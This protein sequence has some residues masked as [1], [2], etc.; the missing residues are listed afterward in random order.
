MSRVPL[1]SV[2]MGVHDGAAHLRPAIA[3]IL[4]QSLDDLELVVVDDASSDATPELLAGFDDPRLVVLRND[5]NIGLTRSLNR[6]LAVARGG[7]VA[8]QDADDRSLPNRLERQVAF[9]DARPDVALC[10]SWARFVDARGGSVGAGHPAAEPDALARELLGE[11]RIFHGTLLARRAVMDELHGY[12][13]AFRYSQDYDLYLRALARHRL[14]NV[15]EELYELRFHDGAISGS[16]Q[17]LQHRYR[18]LARQLHG[19]RAERGSD[20]LDAGVPVDELL[21]RLTAESRGAEFW[22]HRAMYRK[23]TGDMPGYRHALRQALRRDPRSLRT[24]VHLAVAVGGRRAVAAEDRAY[25]RIIA[26]P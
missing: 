7:F 21:E 15:P 18:E 23:L 10:G 20:D 24:L 8:R 1:V 9:L 4:A 19:Q 5:V 6:A 17:E 26:R 14:A 12:R 3:S 11:N 2:L 16:R 25:R 22:R 13:E